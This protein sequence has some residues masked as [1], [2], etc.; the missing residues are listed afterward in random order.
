LT[1][2]A[3]SQNIDKHVQRGILI[4]AT[5]RP[6]NRIFVARGIIGAIEEDL[7]CTNA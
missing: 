5:G 1:Q 3:A 4:E 7:G 6:H 2:R